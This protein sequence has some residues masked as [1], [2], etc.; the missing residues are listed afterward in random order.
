M[1]CP[2]AGCFTCLNLFVAGFLWLGSTKR[3]GFT[4]HWHTAPRAH[5]CNQLRELLAG[6]HLCVC[7]LH[8]APVHCTPPALH[9]GGF[10]AHSKHFCCALQKKWLL[11]ASR[12]ASAPSGWGWSPART[13]LRSTKHCQ[14]LW[15]R[16][17]SYEDTLLCL[18]AA[19]TAPGTDGQMDGQTAARSVPPV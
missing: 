12:A 8:V 18:L 10:L 16:K 3:I 1:K 7:V 2:K 13:Q 5:C 15:W 14:S 9:T 6:F 19:S 4:L 11:S 17:W